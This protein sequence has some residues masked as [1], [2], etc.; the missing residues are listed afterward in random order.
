M[1]CRCCNA[2]TSC[3]AWRA[4]TNSS[5]LS[6]P[7]SN[8]CTF[9]GQRCSSAGQK[10]SS[11]VVQ[12][13]LDSLSSVPPT[14]HSLTAQHGHAMGRQSVDPGPQLIQPEL[15]CAEY[16]SRD[17]H[18]AGDAHP[19]RQHAAE[20]GC[21]G[22]CSR[23]HPTLARAALTQS[24]TSSTAFQCLY[25]VP[26][27]SPGISTQSSTSSAAAV[28]MRKALGTSDPTYRAVSVS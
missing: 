7:Y 6:Q 3:P 25:L 9:P 14:T 26:Y 18:G 20:G 28:R 8:F 13:C 23:L 17:L 24:A 4:A 11:A 12:C 21:N 5:G 16:Q 10:H 15:L 2:P 22:V 19:V 27:S 1:L